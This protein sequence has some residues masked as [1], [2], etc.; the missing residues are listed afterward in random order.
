LSAGD[1]AGDDE[2]GRSQP[3]GTHFQSPFYEL[4]IGEQNQGGRQEGAGKA[5]LSLP[6]IKHSSLQPSGDMACRNIAP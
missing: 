3:K 1:T 5:L 2:S 4:S 6:D